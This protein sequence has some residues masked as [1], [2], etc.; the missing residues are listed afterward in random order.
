[1]HSCPKPLAPDS[2][3]DERQASIEIQ[4]LDQALIPTATVKH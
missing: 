3:L 4:K 1:V 2:L